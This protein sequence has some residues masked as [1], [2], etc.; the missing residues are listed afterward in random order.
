MTTNKKM[1]LFVTIMFTIMASFVNSI[2]ASEEEDSLAIIKQLEEKPWEATAEDSTEKPEENYTELKYVAKK[3]HFN[4][5]LHIDIPTLQKNIN[6]SFSGLLYEDNNIEDDSIRVKVWE[7]G[8]FKISFEGNK[9]SVEVPVKI[10]IQKRMGI[11]GFTHTDREANAAIRIKMETPIQI[12]KAWGIITKCKITGYDWISKPT[13]KLAG[14]DMPIT[15]FVDKVLKSNT[16]EIEKV[17]DETIRENIPFTAYA[18]QLWETIHQPIYVEADSSYK[19]WISITPENILIAPIEGKNNQICT[20]MKLDCKVNIDLNEPKKQ[21][22]PAMPECRLYPSIQPGFTLNLLANAPYSILSELAM[23]NLRGVEFGDGKHTIFVD[24]IEMY[25]T[26]DR[27]TIGLDMTGFVNGR[28]YFT[29]TPYYDSES[30]SI[31]LKDIKYKLK[32][33]NLFHKAVNAIVRPILKNKL[34]KKFEFSLQESFYLIEQMSN[35]KLLNSMWTE[36]IYTQ[37]KIKNIEGGRLFI[38]PIGIQAELS[39]EGEIEVVYK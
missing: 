4:I 32:T 34:E 11:M 20:G 7:Q 37:G 25:G 5:P 3:S 18:K 26:D 27:L 23:Q 13:A 9:L 1:R 21:N 22:I 10:W 8:E 19:A 2:S 36:N 17:V 35:S 30:K 29:S 28:V 16:K 39:I 12:N 38:T 33:K 15:Y 14:W 6:K 31:K 24:N